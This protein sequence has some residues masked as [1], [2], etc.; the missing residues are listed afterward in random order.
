MSN[1]E[2]DGNKSTCTAFVILMLIFINFVVFVC[3][4]IFNFIK[5]LTIKINNRKKE[6]ETQHM[7]LLQKAED[8][9][10]EEEYNR[11]KKEIEE[12]INIKIQDVQKKFPY[13]TRE[14]AIEY[15]NINESL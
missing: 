14:Q 15:I 13:Y 8:R 7:L 5:F 9:R 1:K 10:K 11:M 4:V 12:K 3:K 6:K 2:N